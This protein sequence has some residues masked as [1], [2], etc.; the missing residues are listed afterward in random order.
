MATKHQWSPLSSSSLTLLLMILLGTP[1]S[2]SMVEVW[3][4]NSMRW[5]K[6]STRLPVSRMYLLASSEKITV[7]PPP[8]GSWY[9]RLYPSGNL[10]MRDR[11]VSIAWT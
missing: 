7:L 9:S 1:I 2:D 11:M 10:W 5:V 4:S 6:I 8:V 3:P